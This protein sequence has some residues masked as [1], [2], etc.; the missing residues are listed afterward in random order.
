M[1]N[2]SYDTSILVNIINNINETDNTEYRDKNLI[3]ISKKIYELEIS[4]TLVFECDIYIIYKYFVCLQNNKQRSYLVKI[5]KV[6][7]VDITKIKK[8]I[9][10]FHGSRDLHWDVALL[11]TN[12]LSN[13][14]ITIYLQGNNQGNFELTQPNIEK[15]FISY[16]ENFFEIRDFAPNFYEDLEYVKLVK[17]D[18]IDKYQ[19][20]DFYAV[21]HSNGGVFICLFPIYLP[22]EFK[23]LVS[24]QGGMGLDEWFNIPFEKLDTSSVKP[25]IY[26]YTGTDDI[27]KI[28][29]IKAHEIFTNEGFDY[30]LDIEN[31]L[32][33]TWEKYHESS[34]Y[35]YLSYDI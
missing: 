19:F 35:D 26:F 16:G 10:F 1:N 6:H 13:E 17:K 34:I 23:A 30:K 20:T 24:H 21:G 11:S 18:I 32:Q 15:G 9:M 27:H 3:E 14:F 22:N 12:M 29:C 7:V 2:L 33:H 28:P 5:P 31:G 8:C 25:S 4:N